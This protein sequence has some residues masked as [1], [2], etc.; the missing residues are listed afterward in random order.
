MGG[1]SQSLNILTVPP[2]NIKETDT[3][4]KVELPALGIAKEDFNI[5]IDNGLLT[6]S[7]EHKMEKTTEE[8]KFIRRE[9]SH[10]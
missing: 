5:E 9:F 10:S 6:I 4:F 3:Q 2:V 8:G 7:S 1:S